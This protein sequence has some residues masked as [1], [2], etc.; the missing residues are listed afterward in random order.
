MKKLVLIVGL[1]FVACSTLQAGDWPQ[2]RGP[3]FNGSTDETNL[4]TEWSRTENVAWKASLPG[5]SASTPVV[6]GDRVFVS[7]TDTNRKKL[8]AMCLDR[9]T[10]RT[11]WHHDVA[12]KLR[13]KSRS[14][15]A[16]PSPATD[17]KVVVF[18]YGNGE[19]ATYDLAGEELWSRNIQ[20]DYGWFHYGWTY[21]SS[22]L[23]YDGKL[24]LQILQRD[25]ATDKNETDGKIH[26]SFLLALNPENGDVIWKSVRPSN[27]VAESRESF[28]TPTPAT[29]N[30][31]NELLVIGG[32]ALTGHDLT[33]GR[34]LWRWETWNPK[35]IKHWRHVPSPVAS[36]DVVLVCAPKREPVY[37]IKSGGKGNLDENAIAWKSNGARSGIS[38]DVPTP[39][40]YDGSFFVLYGPN[41]GQPLLSRVEPKTGEVL[42]TAKIPRG[43]KYEA[44][45]LAA[46]GNIYV[47]NFAGV[48]TVV[49]AADG[50]I[51]N[52]IPMDEES[53]VQN[54]ST[55]VAAGGQLFIRSGSDLFCIGKK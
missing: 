14:N 41:T 28:T 32:D 30:G 39:A 5:D 52:S 54:R 49:N 40:F 23:L 6:W 15:F 27:A 9:K 25:V 18:F 44:S 3:N 24:I 17:G 42:W 2:F 53:S 8:K 51:I 26:N 13:R 38:S 20:K 31:R 10:G 55:I 33:D 50:R 45:P 11:L 43:T 22:P 7:T 46:D 34:E 47:M 37:A 35:H 48:V 21:S 1:V 36:K 29:I 19:M 16:S 4:P 12:G